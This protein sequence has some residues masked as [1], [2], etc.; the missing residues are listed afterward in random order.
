MT[1]GRSFEM[2]TRNALVA[3]GF[4]VLAT[5]VK[6]FYNRTT[7]AEFDIV[8]S[9]FIVEVKSGVSYKLINKGLMTICKYKM[10]P[11]DFI[12]FV[13][14]PN[15]P[16]SVMKKYERYH[17]SLI[18]R[19]NLV[20]IKNL[21]EIFNYTKPVKNISCDSEHTFAQLMNTSTVNSVDKIY[22][23]RENYETLYAKL[24]E[25]ARMHPDDAQLAATID[26]YNTAF[27]SGKIVF[28]M[29]D[30]QYIYP[31]A[32]KPYRA[33]IKLSELTPLH[34]DRHFHYTQFTCS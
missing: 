11:P 14:L 25:C 15:A 34:F 18:K 30:L 9:N 8:S 23:H 26:R 21:K 7:L 24:T 33:K 6:V 10:L 16:A 19:N 1:N 27:T 2:L 31:Y 5:N 29:D 17:R 12:Y 20:F 4:P 3:L 32:Q 22:V 28:S 13:Y